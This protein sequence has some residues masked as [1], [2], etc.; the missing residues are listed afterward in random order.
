MP[1]ASVTFDPGAVTATTNFV[2]G[3]WVTTVP[4]FLGGNMFLSG[5]N[6][7]VPSNLPG[8]IHPVTWSGTIS[9]NKP[10]VSVNWQ[11]GAAVYTAFSADPSLLGVKPVDDSKASQYKNGDHAGTPESFKQYVIGGATGGGGANYTGGLSGTASVCH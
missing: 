5:L 6:F 10:G 1:N 2:G 9:I 7:H 11:W 3:M 4:S 8:S